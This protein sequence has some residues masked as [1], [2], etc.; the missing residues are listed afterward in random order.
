MQGPVLYIL[1]T[2]YI[3]I[4]ITYNVCN[5]QTIRRKTRT[6]HTTGINCPIIQHCNLL[7]RSVVIAFYTPG[8]TYCQMTRAI[9]SLERGSPAH[10]RRLRG[11]GFAG[12]IIRDGNRDYTDNSGPVQ[13]NGKKQFQK[14]LKKNKKIEKNKKNQLKK[15]I[16][17]VT[18]LGITRLIK[19]RVKF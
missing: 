13:T 6:S 16:I 9:N 7:H 19:K 17:L 12:K 15:N 3:I 4:S 8:R 10:F 18:L 14:K 5:I 2:L 11:L 1:H